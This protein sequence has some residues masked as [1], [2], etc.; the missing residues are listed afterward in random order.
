[1]V[2]VLVLVLVLINVAALCC[3]LFVCSWL[4]VGVL[5][6][7]LVGLFVGW[8]VLNEEPQTPAAG[9]RVKRD[10]ED[11]TL[12]VYIYISIG[13]RRYHKS[14]KTLV[15]NPSEK[16]CAFHIPFTAL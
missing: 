4:L 11:L 9:L 8:K 3:C 1:M 2:V 7:L 16:I 12:Y 14:H 6:C 10:I 5:V 15:Q 13:K